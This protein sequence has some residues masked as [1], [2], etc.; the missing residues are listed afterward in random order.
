L[1]KKALIKYFKRRA[2]AAV[3]EEHTPSGAHR[4]KTVPYPQW[5]TLSAR[6]SAKN[7]AEAEAAKQL[8][9]W[10]KAAK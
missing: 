2:V 1:N 3:R 8:G 6:Q 9:S 10:A 7:I 4:I 5:V